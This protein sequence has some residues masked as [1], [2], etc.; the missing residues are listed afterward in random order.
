M[1]IIKDEAGTQ[2]YQATVYNNSHHLMSAYGESSSVLGA[3]QMTEP[4]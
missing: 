3:L 1:W 2:K 4:S